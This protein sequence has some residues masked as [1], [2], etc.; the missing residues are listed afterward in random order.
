MTGASGGLRAAIVSRLAAEG[1][2][3]VFHYCTSSIAGSLIDQIIW[4]EGRAA[5]VAGNIEACA[6]IGD[7]LQELY[8][9]GYAL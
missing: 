2:F 8:G 9:G 3:V 6:G 4:F 5:R 7:F 1:D